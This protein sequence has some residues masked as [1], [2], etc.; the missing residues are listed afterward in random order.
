MARVPT[1]IHAVVFYSIEKAIKTYRQFAQRRLVQAGSA[2]TI[3]QWLVLNILV[4]QPGIKQGEIADEV[5][6]DKAS[7]ARIIDLLVNAGHVKR[8]T[9]EHDRRSVHLELTRSG[10]A[11]V[12]KLAP[13]V[14][15]YRLQAL[16]GVTAKEIKKMS[17]TLR[18]LMD[19]C[20][21]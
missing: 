14:K 19:N 3:D 5:F 6:K 4:H 18:K 21:E 1:D 2:I 12:A 13:I 17:A 16:Q 8:T 15:A 7:V 20:D 9:P 11:Q 10:K